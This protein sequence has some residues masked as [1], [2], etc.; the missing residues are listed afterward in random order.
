[1]PRWFRLGELLALIALLRREQGHTMSLL[2]VSLQLRI[3]IRLVA[4]HQQL[5]FIAQQLVGKGP[6]R[7]VGGC[8][9]KIGDKPIRRG[10]QM[11]LEAYL[12]KNGG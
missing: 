1:M 6:I 12:L 9:G 8:Q 5:G 4:D 11:E 10:Q 2:E 3:D 7:E